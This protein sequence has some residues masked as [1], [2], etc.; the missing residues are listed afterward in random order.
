MDSELPRFP[1]PEIAPEEWQRTPS[2]VRQ[3]I[4]QMARCLAALEREVRLLRA[5]NERLREQRRRS[6]HRSPGLPRVPDLFQLARIYMN[7]EQTPVGLLALP[8]AGSLP[9]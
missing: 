2:S 4:L 3:M 5:E 8:P 6:S 9:H 7:S 1:N